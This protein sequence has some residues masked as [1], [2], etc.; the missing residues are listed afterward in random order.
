M[1]F[2][3]RSNRP[4]F[5]TLS[6]GCRI[7]LLVQFRSFLRFS[8]LDFKLVVNNKEI[9]SYKKSP[10][11]LSFTQTNPKVITELINDL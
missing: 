10:G 5:S 9:N 1:I 11:F 3:V 8:G 6:F 7:K 2:E 4:K